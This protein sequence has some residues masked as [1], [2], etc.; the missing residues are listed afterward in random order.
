[1]RHIGVEHEISE[2]PSRLRDAT[3]IIV[4][5]V[6]AF[7]DAMK[8]L[9]SRSLVT[10]IKEAAD[11]GT[12]MLGICLG[13][14]LLATESREFG[15]H[16]GLE[17]IPGVVKRLPEGSGDAAMRVPNVGWRTLDPV[18][19]DAYMGDLDAG[20]MVYFVHSYAPHPTASKHVAATTNVNGENI[21]AII[22]NRNVVGYQFHPEKSG[23]AGLK[24]LRR[25]VEFRFA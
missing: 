23:R 24:L 18:R 19:S 3:K 6:G 10:P 15:T 20:A 25:F 22:R 9:E 2:D 16:P 8:G 7:G 17:L 12:P 13:M 21:P 11:R 4:P 14:Q 1:M 5:G